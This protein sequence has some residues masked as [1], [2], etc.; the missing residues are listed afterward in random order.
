MAPRLMAPCAKPV[1]MVHTL[2]HKMQAAMPSRS[3]IQCPSRPPTVFI[4]VKETYGAQA[5]GA[6]RKAGEYGAHAPPQDAG[7]H[8]EPFADPMPQPTADRVHRREG[9]VWRPG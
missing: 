9:N 6:L 4:A 3:P 1:S 8:A 5:D 7:S 2:H